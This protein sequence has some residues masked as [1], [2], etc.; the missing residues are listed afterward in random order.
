M[1]IRT[2]E[3]SGRALDW[4]VAKLEGY[5]LTS[6][7]ISHLVERNGK[8]TILGPCTT[9]QNIPCGYS[10]STRWEQAGPII[11]RESISVLRCDDDYG[12]DEQGFCNNVRIPVW[13]ATDGQHGTTTFTEHQS[14]EE[15]F[16]I[17]ARDVIYG[18]THLV[19]AMRAYVAIK[20][21]G[22]ETDIPGQLAGA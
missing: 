15:M 17:D 3:L 7:G 2:N 21:S 19:A 4:A 1:K 6:D 16:Q 12:V 22:D 10:P 8:L 13:C 5:T 9:G 14:H 20:T 11:E 18:P